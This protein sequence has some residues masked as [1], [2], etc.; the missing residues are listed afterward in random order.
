MNFKRFTKI[1]FS[2]YLLTFILLASCNIEPKDPGS[3]TDNLLPDTFI[4]P[5]PPEGSVDN[6]FRLR[7]QWRGND[8]DGRIKEF[9]Y[10][11]DGPLYDN[12]WITTPYN[13]ADLKLPTGNY[14]VEVRSVDDNN[15]VDATPD[16]RSFHVLG[17]THAKGILVIDDDITI[18][19]YNDAGKDALLDSL[20]IIAGFNSYTHWD[21]QEKFGEEIAVKFTGNGVDLNGEEYPGLSAFS[22]IIWHTGY[23]E[24]MNISKNTTL[25]SDYLDTGGNLLLSG[26]L[27]MKSILGDTARGGELATSHIGRKYLKIRK[28]K[29]ALV[30]TD[31]LLGSFPGFP[32]IE[33]RYIVPTSGLK[34]YL[35]SCTDQL[36]PTADADVIYTFSNNVYEDDEFTSIMINDEEFVGTPVG[37]KYSSSKYN[38]IV[39]GFP[40]VRATKRGRKYKN[41]IM[42]VDNMVELVRHILVDEF[43]EIP[44]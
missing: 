21:F 16:K 44:N 32:D 8:R 28:A 43:K 18:D 30:N 35:E 10:R 15:A 1:I 22:T 9:Q 41:N 29:A 24:E 39:L 3:P 23:G 13:Y 34:I 40:L 25:I 31:F 36:I 20:L 12:T 33:T 6:S 42:N 38:S 11:I 14:I 26:A 5:T 7:L 37:I 27:V 4:G 2:F 17:P 19:D